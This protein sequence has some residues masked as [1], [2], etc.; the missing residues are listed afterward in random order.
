[1]EPAKIDW[2][3]LE[4][5]FVEDKLY[6]H[7]NAPKWVDFLSLDHSLNDHADEAWFCKPGIILLFFSLFQDNLHLGVP[8]FASFSKRVLPKFLNWA[9]ILH[10]GLPKFAS[11]SKWVS[12]KF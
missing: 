9:V 7:I 1:M 6:E 2:K 3:R 12:P 4:W 5:S 11:F 8:N 10:L